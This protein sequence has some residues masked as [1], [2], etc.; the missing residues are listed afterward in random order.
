PRPQPDRGRDD[1]L[2]QFPV[3]LR[4]GD[5]A[6]DAEVEGRP[7]REGGPC[8]PAGPSS[9]ARTLRTRVRAPTSRREGSGAP[10]PVFQG[11]IRP[12]Q[13]LVRA[14]REAGVRTPTGA[15]A[16]GYVRPKSGWT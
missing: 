5:L 8:P 11:L 10:R 4:R 7:S 12:S 13:R 3:G 1:R 14:A 6:A 15:S 9:R 16:P 2:P